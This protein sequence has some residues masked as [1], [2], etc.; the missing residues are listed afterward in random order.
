MQGSILNVITTIAVVALLVWRNSRPQKVTVARFWLAP[1]LL[2]VITGFMVY[3]TFAVAR[4]QLALAGVSL[5]VG[6]LLGIPLGIVRGHHSAVR[7]TDQPG[8]FYIDPSLIVMMIWLAAFAVRFGLR[9]ILPNAGTAALAVSDGFVVFAIASV[10]AARV[11]I[12]QKYQAL[13]AQAARA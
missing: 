13:R 7:L 5:V 12:F 11:M 6:A 8:V 4:D 1:A 3:S 9:F 2:V 10:L